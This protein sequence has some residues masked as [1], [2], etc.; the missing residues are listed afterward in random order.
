VTYRS[1]EN[2]RHK[3]LYF[4]NVTDAKSPQEK[5]LK[6]YADRVTPGNRRHAEARKAEKKSLIR[7]NRNK[8]HELLAEVKLQMSSE[9]AELLVG[10]S[11]QH[12]C[13]SL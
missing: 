1:Q 7:E 6:E 4:R 2:Q 9:D 13:E 8:S 5:K 12:I 3:L 10:N 11:R